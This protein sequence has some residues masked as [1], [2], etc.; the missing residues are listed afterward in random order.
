M[1]KNGSPASRKLVLSITLADL[2]PDN[3]EVETYDA[4]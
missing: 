1:D 4:Q 3:I 2:H